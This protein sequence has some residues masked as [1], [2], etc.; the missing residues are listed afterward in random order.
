MA[1]NWGDLLWRFLSSLYEGGGPCGI[2]DAKGK[3]VE[4]KKAT[5]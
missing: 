4:E 1:Y 5:E 3:K 2:V